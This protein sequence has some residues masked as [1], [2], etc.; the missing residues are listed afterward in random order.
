MKKY[1]IPIFLFLVFLSFS[2]A[3]VGMPQGG[4]YDRTPPKVKKEKPQNNS[5]MFK[6]N[7]FEVEFDEYIVLNNVQEE[8]IISPPLK[9]KPNVKASLKK[10]E[11]SW[12]DTLLENTTY[13]FDFG[14]S[15]VDYREGNILNGFVY[16]F[17]S[18]ETIDT[19]EY[20]GILVDAYTLKPIAKKY[21]MLYKSDSASI[22]H[23]EKPNY[24]TRSDSSGRFHFKN[25]A[26]GEYQ[27][28]ALDDKNQNLIYD[29]PNEAIAFSLD[30]IKATTY[31]IS[32]IDT[33]KTLNPTNDSIVNDNSKEDSSYFLDNNSKNI[34]YF[35]EPKDTSIAI[36]STKI[37]SPI[38]LNIVFSNP[39]TDSLRIIFSYPN[40]DINN[41]EEALVYFSKNKDT[42]NIWSL[43][44][45]MDS[46]K[47]RITDIGLDE[48]IEQIYNENK[49]TSKQD[50]FSFISPLRELAYYDLLSIETP[51]PCLDT[52]QKL[53][54]IINNKNDSIYDTITFS[55][56]SPFSLQ[57]NE[58]LKGN[59]TY[60]V[61]VDEGQIKDVLR[62]VNDKLSFSFEV[63]SAENYGNFFITIKDSL[64][65]KE[66][67]ILILEDNDKKEVERKFCKKEEKISFL[68]LKQ[69]TYFL[70]LIVDKNNNGKW[71]YGQYDKG[72]LPERV[73]IYDKAISIRENWDIEEIW[74]IE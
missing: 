18:G 6:G 37:P 13:I 2:C 5:T 34:L 36:N 45:R 63:S 66:N 19:N 61:R 23:K 10:L 47:V 27:I 31:N 24:L 21:V 74:Q 11:V 38:N 55:F 68:N 49:K 73:L 25:I 32:K 40:I 1:L 64:N 15:I 14:T 52:T 67:Y 44:N 33:T 53:F 54:A 41:K 12:S 39:T 17:S 57:Y 28:M 22:F 35:F 7:G 8:L 70:R 46:I 26:E 62:R 69:G 16:S 4:A 29:L 48:N 9:E 30:R 60:Q 56:L 3:K 65:K 42:I 72:I 50:T 58:K 71:D 20:K 59:N 51:Y 43:K